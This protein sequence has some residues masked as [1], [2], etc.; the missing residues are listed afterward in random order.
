MSLTLTTAFTEKT[1]IKEN[2]LFQLFYDDE[3]STDFFGVS[4]YDTTVESVDY[5]GCVL[6]KPTIRESISLETSTAKTSSV[7]LTLANF[8]HG[9]DG[10]QFSRR[11]FNGTNKYINRKVKI[12]IH[13]NDTTAIANCVLIYTGRLEQI[14]HTPDKINLSIV[15]QRP[16]DKISIPATKTSSSDNDNIYFPIAYGD[17]T[18]N[19]EGATAGKDLRPAPFVQT[20]HDGKVFAS[21]IESS[22]GDA[23]AHLYNKNKDAFLRANQTSANNVSKLGGYVTELRDNGKRYMNIYPFEERD[24]SPTSTHGWNNKTNA[25]D[26]DSDASS[27]FAYFSDTINIGMGTSTRNLYLNVPKLDF[28]TIID[29]S[30]S[31]VIWVTYQITNV[32]GTGTVVIKGGFENESTITTATHTGS[33]NISETQDSIRIFKDT[34]SYP[35]YINLQHTSVTSDSG[36]FSYKLQISD[37]YLRVLFDDSDETFKDIDMAYTGEDGLKD[38]G[39]NSN[40]DI[41][42]IHEAHRD[43]LTRFTS[44][45]GTPDNWSGGTNLNGTKDWK[46]R[47]WILESTPLIDV[48]EKLA[49]EGGFIGRFNGQGNYQYIY[50][51]DSPSTS[52]ALDK[53][54]ISDI[55][56]SLSSVNSLVTKMNIEYEKHPAVGK[57]LSSATSVSDSDADLLSIYNIASDENEKRVALDAYVSPAIN[58][59]RGSSSNKNDCFYRYYDH[60]LGQPRII[61]D[62]TIIN[63]N[64]LGLDVGDIFTYSDNDFLAFA[65]VSGWDDYKFMITDVSRSVGKL[66]ITARDIHNG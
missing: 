62:F 51:P 21:S 57:Y 6:N 16:W 13:P 44:Y 59:S 25:F 27:S 38:N 43:L 17:F 24:E 60:I 36:G 7:S 29:D 8:I 39:W 19:S 18:G 46:I 26:Q 30:S 48:L 28:G 15:A 5:K 32:S 20:M 22:T 10:R 35:N 11:L 34:S 31:M 1:A 54:D 55:K 9:G 2:W 63:P 12:Y 65:G 37:I 52:I 56:I 23:H 50:I 61:L 64:Y 40:A 53:D 45:S 49:F 4:Y 42:E 14:S 3:S 41:T 47:Y 58:E 66:K 33:G